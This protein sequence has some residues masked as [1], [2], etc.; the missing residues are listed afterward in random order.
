LCVRL[1]AFSLWDMHEIQAEIS[2]LENHTTRQICRAAAEE[3]L[4]LSSPSIV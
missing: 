2:R 1:A 4:A 3:A